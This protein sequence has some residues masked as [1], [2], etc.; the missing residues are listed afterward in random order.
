MRRIRS[1]DTGPEL[2]VRRIVHN[3]GFRYR[4]H[5]TYLPGRPDIV[6]VRHGK[7]IDVRGCFWHQH[8]GCV[9]SHLPKT[10]MDYWIAK[11]AKN[12]S[13]DAR[14][15]RAWRRAGWMILI[16]WECQTTSAFK[17]EQRI[18]SFLAPSAKI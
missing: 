11:L 2:I 8:P 15:V 6:L 17:L 1:K 4:L 12:V 5:P 10:R 13:R 9:D 18:R 16:V 3:V 14:N 7:I